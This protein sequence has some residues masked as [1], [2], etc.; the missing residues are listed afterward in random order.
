MIDGPS[1]TF[2]ELVQGLSLEEDVRERLLARQ[3]EG[4]GNLEKA[5]IA[6]AD[7]FEELQEVESALSAVRELPSEG[8]DHTSIEPRDSVSGDTPQVLGQTNV[9][10]GTSG[11][12]P[13]FFWFGS[14]RFC[15][16]LR[17]EHSNS[18]FIKLSLEGEAVWGDVVG[19]GIKLDARAFIKFVGANWQA[20]WLEGFPDNVRVEHVMQ[21]ETAAKRTYKRASALWDRL[22]DQ[23]YVF[24]SRHCLSGLFLLDTGLIWP[25]VWLVGK[26]DVMLVDVPDLA[27]R[28]TLPIDEVMNTLQQ[29]CDM[30][31]DRVLGDTPSGDR[32]LVT[33]RDAWDSRNAPKSTT[34]L[35]ELFTG[36]SDKP[37]IERI[38]RDVSATSVEGIRMHR[39]EILAAAR[40][41]PAGLGKED[42][43]KLLD[44]IEWT[45]KV[46]TDLLDAVT[47][48]ANRTLAVLLQSAAPPFEQGHEIAAWL[49]DRLGYEYQKRIRVNELLDQWNVTRKTISLDTQDIDAIAFWGP[50]R[51]PAIVINRNGMFSKSRN[52]RRITLAHE[53]CHLVID[54]RG[55]LPLVDVLGGVA[56]E[57]IEQ[58]A[59]AFA[60][61]F[62]LPQRYVYERFLET[63]GSLH[64][65]SD[66]IEPLM[67]SFRVSRWVVAFQLKNALRRFH[68]YEKE[69]ERIFAYVDLI[70]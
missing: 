65:I 13:G 44:E 42:L 62:L 33:S 49:R 8:P 36:V 68:R 66:S 27:L 41:R 55:H 15:M 61:E 53:I 37:T 43:A 47:D 69:V 54:R 52:G 16:G 28:A 19:H 50:R 67:A 7:A 20:L 60:A 23:W 31:A 1:L 58:R 48:D 64:E 22:G 18:V 14:A 40:M 29:V 10:I 21:W 5:V 2:E 17:F 26:D 11:V 46:K 45:P 34:E 6:F 9:P 3:K 63:D 25:D 12:S 57:E 24:R 35:I 30:I 32:K 56:P 70:T 51:G 59:R 4:E 39:S 38:A